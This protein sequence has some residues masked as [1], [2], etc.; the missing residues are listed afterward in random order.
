MKS[1]PPPTACCA[2][3]TTCSTSPRSKSDRLQ[4]KP[5]EFCLPEVLEKTER[6]VAAE[7]PKKAWHFEVDI[8][9]QELATLTLRG[10]ALR[11]EQILN[12]L[13]GN[14]VKFTE[15]QG[16]AE[17][18]STANLGDGRV[19]FTSMS[20]IPASASTPR[21]RPAVYAF[22]QADMSRAAVNGG[23]GLGLAIS[24]HLAQLM[25]GD[26]GVSS[27]PGSRQPASGSRYPWSA[28]EP[29]RIQ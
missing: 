22:E 5:V 1:T 13:V 11:L 8:A 23:A 27:Q 14:A 2:S 4:L 16:N 12:S 24:K 21:I 10:D 7:S 25:G 19:N 26:M 9:R 6:L 17:G 29:L 18:H 15:G 28:S 20:S 3:S